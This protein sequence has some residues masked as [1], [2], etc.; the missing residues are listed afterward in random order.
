[1][2]SRLGKV[3]VGGNSCS[4]SYKETVGS[5]TPVQSSL[6]YLKTDPVLEYLPYKGHV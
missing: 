4:S 1:M 2:G 5:R 3:V 6:T